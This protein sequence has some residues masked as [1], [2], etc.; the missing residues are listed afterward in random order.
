ML[1]HES[2]VETERERTRVNGRE[3]GKNEVG[4]CGREAMEGDLESFEGARGV[5]ACGRSGASGASRVGPLARSGVWLVGVAFA[6]EEECVVEGNPMKEA[7]DPVIRPSARPSHQNRPSGSPT[8]GRRCGPAHA[9]YATRAI[10]MH[11]EVH[12]ADT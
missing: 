9:W 8:I 7:L 12:A 3:M 2:D 11:F 4:A 10:R 6:L 5:A 1:R